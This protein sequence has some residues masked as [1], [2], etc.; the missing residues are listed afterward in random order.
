M[1]TQ[2][3]PRRG[4]EGMTVATA[5]RK[6][7][8]RSEEQRWL[9]RNEQGE[10][11]GPVDFDTLKSWASDGR[12]APTNEVSENGAQWTLATTFDA[13]EMDWVAEVTPGTFYGPIHRL[14]MDELVRDGSI[15]ATCARFR[16]CAATAAEAETAARPSAGKTQP[17]VEAASGGGAQSLSKE[18][19]ETLE[20]RLRD[21]EQRA[22]A[23]AA[24]ARRQQ[25]VGEERLRLAQEQ[26]AAFASELE[27]ARASAQ[28]LE[29]RLAR[30]EQR[31]DAEAEGA[32]RQRAAVEEQL[33]L[34]LQQGAASAAELERS[35]ASAAA[36]E[37]R[38]VQAESRAAALDGQLRS[39]QDSAAVSAADLK[40]AQ[41]RAALLE[42]ELGRVE[43]VSN[44]QTEQA[45]RQTAAYEEQL[46]VLR[47]EGLAAA[48]QAERA[49]ART[50]AVEQRLDD[51]EH[52]AAARDAELAKLR[53]ERA[54][55][56]SRAAELGAERELKAAALA[57]QA[58]AFEA[59]RQEFRAALGHA[60]AEGAVRTARLA[61][62]EKTLEGKVAA[63]PAFGALE[64]QV[65]ALGAE[66]AGLR[67]A[68]S[69]EK[70]L[71]QQAQ[72]RCVSL[73]TALEEARARCGRQEELGGLRDEL[74]QVRLQ[75]GELCGKV[76]EVRTQTAASAS[77]V[78]DGRQPQRVEAEPVDA[79]VLPPERAPRAARRTE[80]PGVA[81]ARTEKASGGAP[82]GQTRSAAG[83]SLAELEMQ[84]RRELERLGAQGANLFR[85]K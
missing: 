29:E 58:S 71:A 66:V 9:V 39:A 8:E 65:R 45:K 4:R 6:R 59:E 25:A 17:A 50:A 31:A 76:A 49:Q 75:L 52:K 12:L 69:G 56:V 30:A 38:L 68:L 15:P 24:N 19:F 34:A 55:A 42:K 32:G 63:E 13:L 35:R 53:E 16:R 81:G 26:C 72:A 51:A 70:E 33:R 44:E 57:S 62:L 46:R 83:L 40:V 60:Q 74:R 78:S 5:T 21:A 79:E 1:A 11:F 41:E 18:R 10:T 22:Q 67:Q 80:S 27:R 20:A 14:A 64:E 48:A 54:S 23:E 28:A 85:K 43:Q 77:P 73:E 61:Q 7:D 2:V 82:N 3:W 84:A 36:F 37:T 47:Q